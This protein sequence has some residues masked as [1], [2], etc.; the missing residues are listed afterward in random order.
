MGRGATRGGS[1]RGAVSRTLSRSL[2]ADGGGMLAEDCG[3]LSSIGAVARSLRFANPK[4]ELRRLRMSCVTPDLG[5]AVGTGSDGT[6]VV[7]DC[8]GGVMGASGTVGSARGGSG[9]IGAAR[10]GSGG[11][12]TGA[13]VVSGAFAVVAIGARSCAFALGTG[14][15]T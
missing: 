5:G 13:G 3:T 11:G 8:E 1:G 15:G 7:R 12:A 14:S 10:W 4:I 2:G 6:R 9:M